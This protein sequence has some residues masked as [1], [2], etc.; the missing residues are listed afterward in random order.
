MNAL[1]QVLRWAYGRYEWFRTTWP[2]TSAWFIVAPMVVL[3][4]WFV[5]SYPI[6]AVLGVIIW[7]AELRYNKAI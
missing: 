6:I 7:A 4:T 2:N 1:L 3:M 5:L